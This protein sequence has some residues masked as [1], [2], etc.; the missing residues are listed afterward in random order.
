MKILG[1]DPSKSTGWAVVKGGLV[2]DYGVK[3]FKKKRNQTNGVIFLEFR[4]W[5]EDLMKTHRPDF[6][7]VEMPHLRGA[8]ATE[9][10]VGMYTRVLEACHVYDVEGTSVQTS[11]LKLATAGHGKAGKQDMIEAVM[12]RTGKNIKIDDEADALAA[13]Y[14]AVDNYEIEDK[15]AQAEKVVQETF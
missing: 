8:A 14:Y 2:E 11:T 13:C 12:R 7:I 9:I 1:V 3:T 15:S 10:L 4:K 6:V 5:L